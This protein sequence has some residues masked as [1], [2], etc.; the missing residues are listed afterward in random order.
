MDRMKKKYVKPEIETLAIDVTIS[1][2]LVSGP[3][4]G[5]GH[6]HGHGHN[7]G[8]SVQDNPFGGSRPKNV[9]GFGEI[10]SPW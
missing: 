9:S 3:H 8:Q 4:H 5:H 10:N 6:G 1:M 2:C 7:H